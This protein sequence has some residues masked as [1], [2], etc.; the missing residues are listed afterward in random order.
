[1]LEHDP[2]HFSVYCLERGGDAG[3][4]V[5][6]FFEKVDAERSADEYLYVCGELSA[7]GYSHYEVS[8][9]ARPGYES[10]HNRV[11]WD[12][13]EYIGLGPGAHSFVGGARYSNEP[14]VDRYVE[15]R[16]DFAPVRRIDRR[17]QSER[18]TEALM[19]GLR[20]SSGV[21]VE[22]LA[23]DRAVVD[24]VVANRLGRLEAGRLV[25]TDEGFLVLNEIV[26]RLSAPV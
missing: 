8:N 21:A 18:D 13:G 7:R 16:D 25:L 1:V 5:D 11:Y 2:P 23:C 19:L 9:F 12:G 4:V 20:T 26:L 14:S 6:A 17:Q 24:E 22:R 15:R 10:R 3:G